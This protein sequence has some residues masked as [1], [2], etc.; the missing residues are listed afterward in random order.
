M[1]KTVLG[2][3]AIMSSFAFV[4]CGD[5]TGTGGSGTTATGTSASTTK[6][7]TSANGSSTA[8]KASSTAATTASNGSSATGGGMSFAVNLGPGWPHVGLKHEAAVVV[9]GTVVQKV[10]ATGAAMTTFQ[11]TNIP[12]GA[13][14]VH[15]YADVNNSMDCTPP[16]ADHVWTQTITV[17]GEDKTFAHDANWTDVCASFQ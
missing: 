4:A 9:G 16:D 5:D 1:K 7:S 8:T 15:Y 17:D 12:A 14:E 10:T 13:A 2:L 3:V 11:F 6:A